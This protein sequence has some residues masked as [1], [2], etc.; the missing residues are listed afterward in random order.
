MRAPP[1]AD[2]PP[3]RSHTPLSLFAEALRITRLAPG[4]KFTV[5]G[6]LAAGVGWKHADLI[7]RLEEKRKTKAAAF[8]AAKKAKAV[9]RAKAAAAADLDAVNAELA[10]YG[11]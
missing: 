4:R 1:A 9:L 10:Q 7:D 11:H 3:H 5:L 8:Y 6:E 2:P